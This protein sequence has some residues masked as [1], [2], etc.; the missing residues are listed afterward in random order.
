[1]TDRS[2][3]A[4]ARRDRV[5]VGLKQWFLAPPRPH[6][7]V[8]YSRHVSFLE[9]FYDLVYVVVIGQAAHHLA[10]HVGWVGVRDFGIVFGLIWLAW[11]NGTLWHELHGREDGRSRN[12]IFAQMGLIVL[13]AVFAGDA[14]GDDGAQ[15]AVVYVL[16]F[17]WFT[18]QWY[19]VHRIDVDRRYRPTTI[20]YLIGMVVT[21]AAIAVSVP[22]D[23]PVRLGVWAAVV[24][25]WVVGGLVL[26]TTDHT[27]GFGDGVTE[28]LVERF[29]LVT[30]V[31]LGEVVIGVVDG[32]SDAEGR[33]TTTIAVGM[34]GLVIGMGIWWNY[35]DLLGRRVPQ[36]R[37]GRLAVWMYG[38]LP[39]TMAVAAAGAAMVSLVEHAH[40]GRT[41]AATAWLLAA[42]VAVVLASVAFATRALPE[43]E[44]P[45][46]LATQVLPTMA[47]T[48]VGVLATAAIRPG[49]P[50][51]S[52]AIVVA[53]L[54]AWLWLFVAFL[55]GGG[56]PD[57]SPVEIG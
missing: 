57:S 15:F 42:S 32:I 8:E 14:T 17:A 39:L 43:D 35:F 30:I 38:H 46:G 9:L 20:K 47:V 25:G 36:R 16:L 53:L 22:L 44:F 2:D 7:D 37:G 56:Q 23:T 6:G 34:A 49:P 3:V 11:F 31:V 33:D 12:N 24:V 52:I 21:V 51:L 48:I 54:V 29:G 19:V 28:S 27:E 40:D 45:D 10:G 5:R 13:L 26:M 41:P 1:M 50:V 18:W 55:A 4:V